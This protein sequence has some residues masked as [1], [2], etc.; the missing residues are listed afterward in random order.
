VAFAAK[1]VLVDEPSKLFAGLHGFNQ[2]PEA[3]G[4]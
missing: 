2:A 1:H 4:G 3:A